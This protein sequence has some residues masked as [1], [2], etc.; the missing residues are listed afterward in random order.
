MKV[1]L[2]ADDQIWKGEVEYGFEHFLLEIYLYNQIEMSIRHL[3]KKG[4]RYG[5]NL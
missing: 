5:L 2:Q 3:D 1:R 4:K